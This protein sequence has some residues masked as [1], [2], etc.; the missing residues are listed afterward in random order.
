MPL[1]VPRQ[2]TSITAAVPASPYKYFGEQQGNDLVNKDHSSCAS[3]GDHLRLLIKT[4]ST[5]KKE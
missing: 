1:P 3:N 2:S 5:H 4:G